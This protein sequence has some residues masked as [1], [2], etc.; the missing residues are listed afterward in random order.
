MMA[1]GVDSLA[2]SEVREVSFDGLRC[3]LQFNPGRAVSA[4]AK[5]DAKSIAARPCFLCEKNRPAEQRG[6]DAGDGYV[7]LCNPMPIFNPHFTIPTLAHQPQRIDVCL[8]KML[9][10]AERLSG[11]YTVFYNGPR[12]GASAPDHLHLQASPLG[13]TPFEEQLIA[14]AP[15]FVKW[16][17]QGGVTVGLTTEPEPLAIVIAGADRDVVLGQVQKALATLAE[18]F[19]ADP[20]PMLNA[21]ALHTEDTFRVV[22]FPRAS[23]R[24]T[25]FGTDAGQVLVSPGLVDMLGLLIT[26][27]REDFDTLTGEAVAKIY[28]EVSRDRDD[29]RT[30]F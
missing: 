18:H 23:H 5:V 20:E 14:D 8:P 1:Q 12:C 24:P 15:G 28:R 29:L 13:A 17:T 3:R 11:Q 19:P 16:S 9:E 30:L 27:R 26:P 2:D 7:F 21:L 22:L 6:V 10:L 4:S 25:N